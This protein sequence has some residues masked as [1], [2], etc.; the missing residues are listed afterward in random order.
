M[1]LLELA[2]AD[3]EGVEGS[4]KKLPDELL[5]RFDALIVRVKRE[6]ETDPNNGPAE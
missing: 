2:R 4:R 5:E 6:I 3:M 1:E